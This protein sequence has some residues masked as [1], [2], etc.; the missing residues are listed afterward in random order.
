MYELQDIVSEK[1]QMADSYE[2]MQ[3]LMHLQIESISITIKTATEAE[4]H[5]YE[6]N[7]H[8]LELIRMIWM[9]SKRNTFQLEFMCTRTCFY[10]KF[11][12]CTLLTPNNECDYHI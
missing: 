5:E 4:T 1:E 8:L 6:K 12:Q 2:K 9:S 11:T 10:L 3:S 7:F